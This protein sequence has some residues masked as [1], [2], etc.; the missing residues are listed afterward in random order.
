VFGKTSIAKL[1]GAFFT[2][3]DLEAS[4]RINLAFNGSLLDPGG[5]YVKDYGLG[6]GDVIEAELIKKRRG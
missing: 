5:R 1:Y 2:H 6:E 4:L 3:L